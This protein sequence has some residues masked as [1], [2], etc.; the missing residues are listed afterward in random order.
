M[1]FS[2]DVA[3]RVINYGMR[4]FVL[5]SIVERQGIGEHFGPTIDVCPQVFLNGC[6]LT[7]RQNLGPHLAL[8]FAAAL[9]LSHHDCLTG[10]ATESSMSLPS[11]GRWFANNREIPW[12]IPGNRKAKVG[13]LAPRR[14]TCRLEL[15]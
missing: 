2:V 13:R 15:C 8:A 14:S 4:V 6:L 10:A 5:H 11:W 1:H 9:K 7:I 12:W 3:F